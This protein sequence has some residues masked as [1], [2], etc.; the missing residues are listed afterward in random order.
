MGKIVPPLLTFLTMMVLLE[1]VI[2]LAHIPEYLMPPPSQIL[3]KMFLIRESLIFNTGLTMLEA[4]L[5]FLLGCSIGV[6][7]AIAFAHSRTFELSFYPYAIALKT[8]PIVA[9]APLL[10]LWFGTGIFSK[11]VMSALICFFPSIVNTLRGLKSVDPEAMDLFNSLN[12]TSRQIFFKLRLPSSL[13]YIFSALKISATLS[14]VGAIV[15][16]LSG[17]NSGIGYIILVSS[18]KIQ[19]DVLFAAIISSA[20]GGILFFGIVGLIERRV[21]YWYE[22]N[23]LN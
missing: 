12:A 10:I 3:Y 15:G 19:T 13:P 6:F 21:L 11:I 14:V 8:I 23:S 4:V 20:I 1:L 22:G 18:Y 17:S 2:R 9:L 5:G 16:E 7:I